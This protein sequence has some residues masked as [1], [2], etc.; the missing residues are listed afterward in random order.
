M[1]GHIVST[2]VLI[3]VFTLHPCCIVYG[4]RPPV[5]AW[6]HLY[7]FPELLSNQIKLPIRLV[8]IF[9][10]VIS[11]TTMPSEPSYLYCLSSEY[12]LIPIHIA[13]TTQPLTQTTANV[14]QHS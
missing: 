9:I 2:P 3:R 12:P 8:S 13:D 14:P 7:C 10:T 1:H 4:R 11:G 5:W 6:L